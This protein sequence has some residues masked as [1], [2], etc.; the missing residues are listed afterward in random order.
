MKLLQLRV[1]EICTEIANNGLKMDDAHIW[2]LFDSVRA[3]CTPA[4]DKLSAAE[5][6]A[7]HGVTAN[8][9]CFYF[10]LL[11]WVA[12]PDL[13]T[14]R[15]PFAPVNPDAFLPDDNARKAVGGCPVEAHEDTPAAERAKIKSDAPHD[16]R[17]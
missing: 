4:L 1:A 7:C 10:L 9:H 11:H 8:K 15:Q 16:P 13:D 14:P 2:S 5:V 6:I 12:T 3:C 17:Q